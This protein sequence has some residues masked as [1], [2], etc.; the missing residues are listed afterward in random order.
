M[1]EAPMREA[2]GWMDKLR[3]GGVTGRIMLTNEE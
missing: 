2:A 3:E 1:H